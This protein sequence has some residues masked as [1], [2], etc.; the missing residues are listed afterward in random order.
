MDV[1]QGNMQNRTTVSGYMVGHIQ[2]LSPRPQ[3]MDQ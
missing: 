1:F 2:C 3:I